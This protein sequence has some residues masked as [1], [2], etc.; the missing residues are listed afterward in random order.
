MG[1]CLGR[2]KKFTKEEVIAKYQAASANSKLHKDAAAKYLAHVA[3]K[4]RIEDARDPPDEADSAGNAIQ[5]EDM[6]MAEKEFKRALKNYKKLAEQHSVN[7]GRYHD[8]MVT[9]HRQENLELQGHAAKAAITL[10]L[11]P[12]DVGEVKGDIDAISEQLDEVDTVTSPHDE[13]NEDAESIS[14]KMRSA[15]REKLALKRK[16][17][18]SS[19]IDSGSPYHTFMPS[20]TSSYTHVTPMPSPAIAAAAATSASHAVAM[21]TYGYVRQSPAG[22]RLPMP[23][24]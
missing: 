8:L 1:A 18:A 6:T 21:P 4:V 10:D 20:S 17:R 24:F 3:E 19:G 5:E 15:A 22:S 12:D 7:E 23:A 16:L 2:K 14:D 13:L 11:H 9:L